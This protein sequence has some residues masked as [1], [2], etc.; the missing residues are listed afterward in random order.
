MEDDCIAS[1]YFFYFCKAMLKKYKNEENIFCISGSNFQDR[2]IDN[3]SYYFSKYNHCWG[4]ATWRSSWKFN[5]VKIKFWP[6]FKKTSK[7]EKF[8]KNE[9][10]KR[11]WT[12][13]FNDVYEN[14]I[15]SWA[16]PWTLS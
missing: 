14:K 1:K 3:N 2:S 6:K 7:W 16:Y 9:I 4:W 11:Y 15:D 5:D 12:K 8:H 13:I 10:E